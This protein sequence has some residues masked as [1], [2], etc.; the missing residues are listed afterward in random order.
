MFNILRHVGPV[1]LREIKQRFL[2]LAFPA[3]TFHNNYWDLVE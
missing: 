3:M 2:F 1:Y